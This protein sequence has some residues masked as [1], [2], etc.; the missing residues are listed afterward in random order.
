MAN[1]MRN[2][3][4]KQQLGT[5]TAGLKKLIKDGDDVDEEMD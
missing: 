1:E 3:L 4:L 2:Q 5:N